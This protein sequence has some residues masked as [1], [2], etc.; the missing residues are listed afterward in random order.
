M[1]KHFI[2]IGSVLMLALCVLEMPAAAIDFEDWLA[3]LIGDP[4][5]WV[6]VAQDGS[7][8]YSCIQAAIND[9]GST[10]ILVMPGIY[11]ENILITKDGLTIK[12]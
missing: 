2:S 4:A 12:K 8:D 10:E 1:N 7:G 11:K 9:F 5:G 3:S 6:V